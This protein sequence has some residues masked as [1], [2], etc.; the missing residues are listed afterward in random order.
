MSLIKTILFF[1][2]RELIVKDKNVNVH[3]GSL[4]YSGTTAWPT[5][6]TYISDAIFK[7]VIGRVLSPD[8]TGIYGT[9]TLRLCSVILSLFIKI[10]SVAAPEIFYGGAIMYDG[11]SRSPYN[12]FIPYF[13]EN[14]A[15][16]VLALTCNISK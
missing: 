8:Q 2:C 12:L 3:F 5:Q 16:N 9:T 6:N 15:K 4:P 10:Y 14:I 13:R 11:Y 1:Y 7:T